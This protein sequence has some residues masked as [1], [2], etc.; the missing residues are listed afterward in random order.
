MIPWPFS[1]K[2]PFAAGLVLGIELFIPPSNTFLLAF[3]QR[4]A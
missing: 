3:I 4:G 2:S 1:G